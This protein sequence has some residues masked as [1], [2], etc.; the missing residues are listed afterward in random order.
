MRPRRPVVGAL[1]DG[2]TRRAQAQTYPSLSG[3]VWDNT[4][5]LNERTTS[6]GDDKP[7]VT[8]TD[9]VTENSVDAERSWLLDSR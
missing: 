6:V 7:P 3:E 4:T 1:S 2:E 5:E 8:K 9:P